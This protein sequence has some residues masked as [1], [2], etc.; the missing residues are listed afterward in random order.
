MSPPEAK[1][2]SRKIFT[3]LCIVCTATLLIHLNTGAGK[4]TTILLLFEGLLAIAA[5]TQEIIRLIR[6]RKC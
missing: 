5:A 6:K 4:W 3:A 1:K 2:M